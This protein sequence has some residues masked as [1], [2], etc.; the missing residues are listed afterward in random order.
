VLTRDLAVLTGVGPPICPLPLTDKLKLEL[1]A[2]MDVAGSGW[3]GD[4]AD[5]LVEP[6]ASLP[7]DRR[8]RWVAVAG[9]RACGVDEAGAIVCRGY[10]IPA[11]PPP[12]R[13]TRIDMIPQFSCALRED[14]TATCW[15]QPG[16]GTAAPTLPTLTGHYT[17]LSLSMFGGCAKQV[18]G[19]FECWGQALLP[20]DLVKSAREIALDQSGF[21]VV[22]RDGSF[23][24]GSYKPND[25]HEGPRDLVAVQRL[26]TLCGLTRGGEVMCRGSQSTDDWALASRERFHDIAIMGSTGCGRRRDDTLECWGGSTRSSPLR[27]PPGKFRQIAGSIGQVCGVRVDGSVACGG[28]KSDWM[29]FD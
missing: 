26:Y 28:Y 7:R 17:E 13:F 8:Y 9:T 6:H 4:V 20:T 2:K 14:Q 23:A 5:L 3:Q 29:V 11:Q 16:A 24:W 19:G 27:V 1:R 21:G 25:V 18:D 10:P 15:L 22:R 12:G